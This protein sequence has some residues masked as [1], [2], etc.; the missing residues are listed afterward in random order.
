MVTYLECASLLALWFG[1]ACCAKGL[2]AKQASRYESGSKL[3][4]CY[5]NVK[6]L[7][8]HFGKS[9]R[10]AFCFCKY[11][12]PAVEAVG[13]SFPQPGLPLAQWLCASPLLQPE[14]RLTAI[15][16]TTQVI[17]TLSWMRPSLG[18]SRMPRVLCLQKRISQPGYGCSFC[19]A[20]RRPLGPAVSSAVKGAE[21]LSGRKTNGRCC[22]KTA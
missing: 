11:I 22:F 2:R 21:E 10:L 17:V 1:A 19:A 18:R 3:P 4:H 15:R 14:E 9:L 5:V 12:E 8:L 20:S 16:G 6:G 7:V 13:G